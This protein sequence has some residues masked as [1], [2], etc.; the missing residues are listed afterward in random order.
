MILIIFSKLSFVVVLGLDRCACG[1]LADGTAYYPIQFPR[2]GCGGKSV[3]S[4]IQKKNIE[5]CL[6]IR[7]RRN[8]KKL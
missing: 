7:F 1:W 4:Q 6:K 3:S 5:K 2:D 8:I